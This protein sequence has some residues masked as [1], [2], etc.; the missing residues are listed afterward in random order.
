MQIEQGEVD[1]DP[2][3]THAFFRGRKTKL[4]ANLVVGTVD[5][6]LMAALNRKHVML[7]QLG[8]TGKVVILDE[9]HAYDAYMNTYLD[10][11]LN[12]LGAYHVPVILLS[13]TLPGQ[14]RAEL[15]R[16]YLGEKKPVDTAIA[17]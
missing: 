17:A 13:A 15:L 1:A 7:R 10:R 5:Q 3:Q 12:W 14:R 8:L 11:V 9:C 2:L 16:A 6:L 4:L